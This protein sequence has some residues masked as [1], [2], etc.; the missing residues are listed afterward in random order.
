MILPFETADRFIQQATDL[1]Q[2]HGLVKAPTAGIDQGDKRLVSGCLGAHDIGEVVRNDGGK[3]KE[4]LVRN[5]TSGK[6]WWYGL[7]GLRRLEGLPKG[8]FAKLGLK[9]DKETFFGWMMSQF[10]VFLD[11][12]E[13]RGLNSGMGGQIASS[14]GDDASH[15]TAF[16][17]KC[18]GE[19][20]EEIDKLRNRFNWPKMAERPK[21]PE[22]V[23]E[24]RIHRPE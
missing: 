15:V 19:A 5:L 13:E 6:S 11:Y 4:Y 9:G 21:P 10:S 17:R 24:L 22:S 12:A 1:L 23:P 16:E 3:G 18:I 14:L 8:E 20:C 7:E 2:Q